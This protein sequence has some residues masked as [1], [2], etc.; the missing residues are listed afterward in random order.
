MIPDEQ[1]T[2]DASLHKVAP[3][4]K[5]I[6]LWQSSLTGPLYLFNLKSTMGAV[7]GGRP[8]KLSELMVNPWCLN[9]FHYLLPR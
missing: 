9:I 6:S 2:A 1:M 8:W 5:D 3:R 4:V 7:Y